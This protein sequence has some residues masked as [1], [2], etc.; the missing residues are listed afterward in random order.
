[1]WHVHALKNLQTRPHFSIGG[2][3][4]TKSLKKKNVIIKQFPVLRGL[5]CLIKI[6]VEGKKNIHN[7]YLSDFF[8]S[9]VGGARGRRRPGEMGQRIG[10]A[11]RAQTCVTII[12]VIKQRVDNV[13]V[14]ESG[15]RKKKKQIPPPIETTR[16]Q[17][18]ARP[19]LHGDHA[20]PTSPIMQH[21]SEGGKGKTSLN[22]EGGRWNDPVQKKRWKWQII[23]ILFPKV[24]VWRKTRKRSTEIKG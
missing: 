22:R 13:S 14:S 10:R 16:D 11:T 6:M 21:R 1:M 19:R 17:R 2:W 12:Q 9:A 3:R 7:W 24:V 20:S 5:V 23:E 18:R 8:G 4:W 15:G